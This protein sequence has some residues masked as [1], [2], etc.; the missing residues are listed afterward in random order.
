MVRTMIEIAVIDDDQETVKAVAGD[1]QESLS[2]RSDIRISCFTDGESF[3]GQIED[4]CRVDIVFADIEMSP[5]NG[6]EIG[7]KLLRA[8]PDVY[9]V[10]LTAH[11]EYAFESYKLEAYQYILKEDIKTRLPELVS[12]LAAKIDKENNNSR[13]IG[14]STYREKVY[15]RDMIL[16]RKE[17]NRKYIQYVLADRTYRERLNMAEVLKELDSREFV[18]AKRGLAVNIRHIVRFED[19][20]LYMDNGEEIDISRH[21][22]KEVKEQMHA[23][24]RAQ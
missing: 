21:R 3:L 15:Y 22:M 12:R 18:L 4:G 8:D 7:R 20:R 5:V 17:K 19:N 9:L 10:Y 2:E 14:T 13:M 23:F 6:I 11:P 1:I 24:W 16:I